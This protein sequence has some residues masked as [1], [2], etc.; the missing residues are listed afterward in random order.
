MFIQVK[1]AL[2]IINRFYWFVCHCF[3]LVAE[4]IVLLGFKMYCTSREILLNVVL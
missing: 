4:E 2:N 1:Y 3:N